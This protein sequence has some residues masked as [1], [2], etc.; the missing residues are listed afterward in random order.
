MLGLP[1]HR[2]GPTG[3]IPRPLNSNRIDHFSDICCRSRSHSAAAA[4]AR[5]SD[6]S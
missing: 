4:L 3:W 2:S 1:D 6:A 5:A